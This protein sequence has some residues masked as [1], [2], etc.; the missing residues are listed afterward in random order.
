MFLKQIVMIGAALATCSVVCFAGPD[1]LVRIDNRTVSVGIDPKMGGAISWLSW[2]DHPENAVNIH[3]PGRLIQQSYY[4]G[5]S[6]D[7]RADGQH[8]RWSPWTWNPIQAGGVDSWARVTKIDAKPNLIF[9][10]TIPKLWDM[11]NEEAAAVMRQW[12][13]FEPGMPNVIGVRCDFESHRRPGDRWGDKA[14]P[15]HQELPASYFTRSFGTV[16]TYLGKVS[17]REEPLA[18]GP[19][20][21]KVTPPRKTVACFDARGQGVAVFSPVT[22]GEWNIGAAGKGDS[23]DPKAAP[24]IHVAPLEAVRLGPKSRLQ[25]RYWLIVGTEA[26]IVPRL[27]ALW[28]VHA[29]ETIEITGGPSPRAKTGGS[30]K[31]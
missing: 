25:F 19:P 23:T 4:S 29:D 14:V 1:D 9:A 21:G 8:A 26:E 6:V 18:P 30:T 13:G 24:C 20:W 2:P 27:D 28:K 17:W 10:E 31:N 11:P 16:K 7:R 22:T 15:R 3:D 12:T 5:Q